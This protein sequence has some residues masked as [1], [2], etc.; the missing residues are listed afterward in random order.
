MN[1]KLQAA[2]K[3]YQLGLS[4]IPV[5][6][7]KTPYIKW[8]QYQTQAA[9]DK[10][11]RSWWNKWPGAN[12]G[13]V[14]GKISN[15]TVIDTDSQEG[16]NAV[17]EFIP[18]S[19]EFP[20]TK[21]PRGFHNWF[22]HQPG[23]RSGPGNL[24]DTDIKTDGGYI[25]APPSQNGKGKAYAWLEGLK[26]TD[27]RPPPMPSM[28]FDISQSGPPDGR[29]RSRARAYKNGSLLEGD[30]ISKKNEGDNNR[31][32]PT[33]TD[34]IRFEKGYRDN[35]LFRLANHLAKGGMPLEEIEIYLN[36]VADNCRPKFSKKEIPAK[37]KS[38]FKR[39]NDR[40]KG[41]TDEI[42]E[43]IL[44]TSG[45]ISTTFV[46]N[47]QQVT[48]R[49][50]K[51]KIAVILNRLAKE[52]LLEPTGVRAGEYRIVNRSC[53]P[54]DWQN[55]C[56]EPVKDLWLPFELDQLV[57]VML[58]DIILIAGAQNAGKS[59]L[60]MNIAKENRGKYS[61]HYFSSEL[62]PGSFNRRM[63]KFPDVM[64]NQI[65]IN[66]YQ[67]SSNWVDVIKPGQGNLNL[68]DYIELHDK[69][70]QISEIL[71]GLHDKL[72]GALL[73]AAIQKDPNALYGRGGS[74]TQEKPVLSLA[75]DHGV[76]TISKC[77]EWKEG[78]ENPNKMQ[79]HFK[80]LDGCRLKK[81]RGW[82]RPIE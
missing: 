9:D 35:T 48:T 18:D 34:N 79:Y 29:E 78:W 42:R 38:A 1:N 20:I 39:L 74:F 21:T 44:T 8:E 47:R 58:G 53:K 17:F 61:I 65:N 66:F 64:P 25:I 24:K 62:R 73:V 68:I 51:K 26:I 63:Q 60:M 50:E 36:F 52:G 3:Y 71:S 15:L 81:D 27:V 5:K 4:V 59:A 75:L 28:L 6:A 41:L 10:Q 14:T 46:Y 13:I 43:L 7:D 32:Q 57:E 49:E 69:F 16:Q 30:N 70:Y 23:L 37:I 55:A 54:E 12:I 80:I 45:N 33:T 56:T 67:R 19:L 77:K 72:D 11:I 82:H 40:E 22:E 76:A 2:L 31:Q